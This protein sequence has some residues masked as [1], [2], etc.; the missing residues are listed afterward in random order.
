MKAILCYT[1]GF[2]SRNKHVSRHLDGHT[3]ILGGFHLPKVISPIKSNRHSY[4]HIH[5][6]S[7]KKWCI[8]LRGNISSRALNNWDLS[9]SEPMMSKRHHRIE[10][11][12]ISSG[13]DIN[14]PSHTVVFE[15]RFKT[16]SGGFNWKLKW[17]LRLRV[18]H[19]NKS[20]KRLQLWL[21]HVG[22]SWH[23]SY[24]GRYTSGIANHVI[25]LHPFPPP[26][27]KEPHTADGWNPAPVHR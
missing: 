3:G 22:C 12:Q 25:L 11:E 13:W 19:A 6:L 18:M 20:N 5:M 17:T 24:L 16:S 7:S 27:E 8:C 9:E 15:W 14:P 10:N 4:P 26:Q 2:Q 21:L 23:D 1:I